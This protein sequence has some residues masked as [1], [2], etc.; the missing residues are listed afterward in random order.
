MG[1]FSDFVA[2]IKSGGFVMIP[3]L[4]CSLLTWIVI[5]ERWTRFKNLKTDLSTFHLQAST[6]LLRGDFKQLSSVCALHSKLP[7]ARLLGHA[8]DRVES[9]DE[10][11]RQFWM[12][13]VERERL[14]ENQRLKKNLWVLGTIANAAPFIGL[15]GTV[16][17]IL[18]SFSEIQKT[19]R[20]GFDVVAGGISESLI[21][22]ASGI[23][24]GI[25]AVA[26]FNAFQAKLSDLLLHLKVQV[27][28]LCELLSRQTSQKV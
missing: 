4:L 15:F 27:Q 25:I 11:I 5:F 14:L 21:A 22:T 20:G 19:G 24:V 28:D 9:K 8:I 2:F 13:S 17:G 6:L 18:Q 12:E 23:V 16:V 26:A 1:I 3:L 10:A 7:S